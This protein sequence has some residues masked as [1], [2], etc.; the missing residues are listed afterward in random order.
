MTEQRKNKLKRQLQ[1]ARFRLLQKDA[2]FAQPL[3]DMIYVATKNVYRMSNNGYC[4]YFNPDWLQKLGDTEL[5]FIIS[6]QLMH[7]TLGHI[8]REKY[9]KGDRFH[10]A[11]DIVA[12][13]HLSALG[14]EYAKLPHIGRIF[15]ETFYPAERGINLNAREAFDCIPFDPATMTS[16]GRRMYMIDSDAWW[17]KKAD[18]GEEGEIVLSPDDEDPDDLIF[19]DNSGGERSFR[20]R[21]YGAN[22]EE[23]EIKV[24]MEQSDSNNIQKHKVK[25][26]DKSVLSEIESLRNMKRKDAAAGYDAEFVERV[27]HRS[28]SSK[29]D[30][31]RLLDTF[32]QE[33]VCDY[34]FTPPDRRFQNTG[35]FL[36]DYNVLDEKPK[37][38][39]F[40]VDTSASIDDAVLSA[41]Y[42]EIFEILNQFNGAL[43]GVLAFFDTKVYAPT[44]FASIVD[45]IKIIPHG[46]GGTSYKC[47]FDFVRKNFTDMPPSSIVIFT[48]G[49]AEF[50]NACEADNIPVL[51][52]FTNNKRSAP[53]G[54]MARIRV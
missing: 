14:W 28:D 20:K 34:S 15:C 24:S 2:D 5:D 18:R 47:I 53:W 37:E 46:G 29:I 54:R 6:H 48:D 21:R 38:V 31:R 17:D 41:V 7:I 3:R 8:D 44:A 22:D 50:P 26:W 49:D 9:Y 42:S 52:L 51:W 10:L 30:W 1:E 36:P 12:N 11:C 23:N 25:D 32:I 45:L 13:S 27:W 16:G 43:T 40:M 19:E 33:E 4:I 35:F 39:L